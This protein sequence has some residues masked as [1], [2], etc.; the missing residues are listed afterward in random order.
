MRTPSQ[1]RWSEKN[2]KNRLVMD[3]GTREVSRA[4]FNVE[5]FTR[6]E[7]GI[8][9]FTEALWAWSTILSLIRR[10]ASCWLNAFSHLCLLMIIITIITNQVICITAEDSANHLMCLQ[11]DMGSGYPSAH[12]SRPVPSR[13]QLSSLTLQ[14]EQS[15]FM[16]TCASC[17]SWHEQRV[18]TSRRP[19]RRF[20]HH[21]CK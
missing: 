6:A 4:P 9:H 10:T 18:P 11:G 7:G 1:V 3:P 19:W 17:G 16:L 8:L 13:V 15:Y 21:A 2:T 5:G 14:S 20:F 12:V